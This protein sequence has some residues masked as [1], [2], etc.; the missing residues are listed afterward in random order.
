M[1]GVP[2][3]LAVAVTGLALAACAGGTAGPEPSGAGRE[4]P[5][6][7]SAA[8]TALPGVFPA[9]VRL[10]EQGSF[11]LDRGQELAE[12]AAPGPKVLR[13][14][15]PQGSVSPSA[16]REY[17]APEGGMQAY[18]PRTDAP[19]DEGHLRYWVRFP[20][21]FAFAKG[22]K[23][24]GLWGGSKVSGGEQPD[25]DDGFS[26]RLMWRTGGAG[27]VYLYA[28][29]ESGTSLG[30]GD[31]TWPTGRWTCVEQHVALNTPGARD[32]EVTVW[33]DGRQVLRASDL[34][35]RTTDELK[36]EGIFFSTFFGGDERDWA[37]PQDQHADFAAFS[38]TPTRQGCGP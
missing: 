26:T 20:D 27:E 1:T 11:G 36:I 35:Y 8:P 7:G 31:W 30:R 38:L 29:D 3:A 16:T 24:P 19:L 10:R 25:G 2:R 23:L 28:P 13:V 6:S 12:P 32:G 37:S 15:F 5:Q 18:L 9:D 34:V 21:G 22:G 4:P 17:G 33:L 14:S